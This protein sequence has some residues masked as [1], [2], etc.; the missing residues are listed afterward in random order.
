MRIGMIAGE[1][2]PMQGGVGAYSR[3]LAQRLAALGHEVHILSGAAAK[4]T[5]PALTLTTVEG[6]GLDG[7]RAARRWAQHGAFDVINF[8]FQT[9]A[10]RM[11][12]WVH[13]L[14]EALRPTPLI[15]TFHDLRYPYLFP[16]AGPVR[17][18]IVMHLA[19]ASGGAIVT[20]PEDYERLRELPLVTTIPIGSNILAP[21]PSEF[22]LAAWRAKAGEAHGRREFLIA[23]FG[24]INHSKGLDVLVDSLAQL[25]ADGIPA[26]LLIIGGTTGES[27]PTNV[28]YSDAIETQIKRLGLIGAVT[29]TGYLDDQAVGA[30]LTACDVTALPFRDGASYRRGSL[31]AALEYGCALVTTTP[32]VPTPLFV[33]GQ[34]MLLVPP[35]DSAALT[36]ALRR[37]YEAPALH[38]QLRAEAAVLARQFDWDQIAARTAQFFANVAGA[39]A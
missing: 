27:D 12:A 7:L 26:R 33:D 1:Y 9:A 38:D 28:T 39:K 10:Y 32:R 23:H 16:K 37:L 36:G 29:Y 24:L 6:W 35:D 3:I 4:E 22:D 19:R 2:P 34:N 15:T 11:S 5:D 8:Q 31:M 13:F 14:P 20:N 21:L 25:R 17:D 30:Y 18:R